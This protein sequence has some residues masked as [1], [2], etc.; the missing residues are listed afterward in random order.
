MRK[1]QSA[2]WALVWLLVG[3]FGLW[4]GSTPVNAQT[5]ELPTFL[6]PSSSIRASGLSPYRRI[7]ETSD[8][9]IHAIIN[10]GNQSQTCGGISR[11]NLV[12]YYSTDDGANWTC[13]AQIMNNANAIAE[14]IVDS[15]DNLYVVAS[16]P[17]PNQGNSNDVTFTK[18]TKGSGST[19]TAGSPHTIL[20]GN[21]STGYSYATVVAEG[22]TR[23]W[24]AA[25]YFNTTDSNYTINIYYSNSFDPT[26][27]GDWTQ[28]LGSVATGTTNFSYN[29]PLLIRFGSNIGLIFNEDLATDQLSWRSRADSDGLTTWQRR[30]NHLVRRYQPDKRRNHNQ[31]YRLFCDSREQQQRPFCLPA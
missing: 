17:L 7:V 15:S 14:V 16:V 28:S 18:L 10:I 24:L 3:L 8:G 11:T 19:W 25:R 6:A 22:T 9:T 30:V 12:W 1:W 5:S 21:S 20:D 23:F 27:A 29:I 2:V 31:Q 4:Y 26:S 13:G